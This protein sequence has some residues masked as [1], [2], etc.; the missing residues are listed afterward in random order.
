[1]AHLHAVEQLTKNV[2]SELGGALSLEREVARARIARE[3][4]VLAY[5]NHIASHR[6]QARAAGGAAS[7]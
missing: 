1:M 6:V 2:I 4:A 5:E 3:D 7:E